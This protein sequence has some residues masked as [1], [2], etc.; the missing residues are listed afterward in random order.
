MILTKW[1]NLLIVRVRLVLDSRLVMCCSRIRMYVRVAFA[2]LML[3]LSLVWVSFS[4][5]FPGCSFALLKGLDRCKSGNC[6]A[7]IFKGVLSRCS[8][9][10][11]D[12]RVAFAL[13][14]LDWGMV[15]AS[16]CS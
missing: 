8:R 5:Y 4:S 3:D 11:I 13:L 7:H 15:W 16:L 14:M 6:V 1:V 12:V 10:W 2:L 9:V